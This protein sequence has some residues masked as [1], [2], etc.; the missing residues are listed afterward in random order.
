[1]ESRVGIQ[2]VEELDKLLKSREPP[3][4][5]SK[6]DAANRRMFIEMRDMSGAPEL[7]YCSL[8]AYRE[9]NNAQY[10]S[11]SPSLLFP[12][13][14]RWNLGAVGEE[15]RNEK[16]RRAD[17]AEDFRK[18]SANVCME[19]SLEESHFPAFYPSITTR[20]EGVSCG[21][22]ALDFSPPELC[23][24]LGVDT[25]YASNMQLLCRNPNPNPN[26]NSP[27]STYQKLRSQKI[28]HGGKLEHL[29]GTG[30]AL[31]PT[32]VHLSSSHESSSV[33]RKSTVEEVRR[34]IL[35]LREGI[36]EAQQEEWLLT[37]ASGLDINFLEL[38]SE[39]SESYSPK[40][41]PTFEADTG[42]GAVAA[43]VEG[44]V[45]AEIGEDRKQ[46]RLQESALIDIADTLSAYTTT[47]D[48]ATDTARVTQQA[49]TAGNEQQEAEV[50]PEEVVFS[51]EKDDTAVDIASAAEA[52]IETIQAEVQKMTQDTAKFLKEGVLPAKGATSSEASQWASI[53]TQE[54][55]SNFS[56][57]VPK[58]ALDVPF[59]LDDFQKRAVVHLER[60]ESVFVGAHTSAGKT[61]VAEYA[62]ALALEHRTRVVYTSPIKALSNQKFRDFQRKFG[63][64]QV[65]LIT[66]DVSLNP[67]GACLV[68]T[69]EILRSMLYRGA[70]IVRD[71]EWVVFDEVHY[72]ND[73]DRGVVWEEVIIMLPDEVGLIFLSATTPNTREFSSWIGRTKRKNVFVI[74]TDKRPVPL[75]HFLFSGKDFHMIKDSKG[76]FLTAGYTAAKKAKMGA[77]KPQNKANSKSKPTPGTTLKAR[78]KQTPG[79]SSG[80]QQRSRYM[81]D[82]A[83]AEYWATLVRRLDKDKLTPTVVFTFSKKKCDERAG[84][85]TTIDL[86]SPAEKSRIHVLFRR[87]LARLNPSDRELPQVQRI[88]TLCS[89][90]IAVHHGGLLPILKEIVEILFARGLIKVL[91]ATETFAIGVNMPARAVVFNGLRKHD[92]TA[93]RDLLPGEYT[94]MAGRAGRRGLDTV[95]TVII[96]M[97]LDPPPLETLTTML[98]GKATKLQSR[99]RL[100]YNLILNLLRVAELS[101]AEMMKRSFSEFAAQKMMGKDLATL[102]T[103]GEAKLTYLQQQLNADS[104]SSAGH[105]AIQ[106]FQRLADHLQT[107]LAQLL[108]EIKAGQFGPKPA[109]KLL[110][111]GRVVTVISS[112]NDIILEPCRL[113]ASGQGSRLLVE[114]VEGRQTDI[115]LEAI[116]VVTTHVASSRMELNNI[117]A[118][119]KLGAGGSSEDT[120]DDNSAVFSPL[121]ADTI[122]PLSD[123]KISQL[124]FVTR[125]REYTSQLLTLRESVCAGRGIN[126]T[127]YRQVEKVNG[128]A[129]TLQKAKLAM[130]DENLT[131]FPDFQSRL[132]LLK[133]RRYIDPLDSTVRLKGR[134]SSEINTCEELILTEVVFENVL[135]DLDA[136]ECAALLSALVFQAKTNDQP[137]LTDRLQEAQQRVLM[138][139]TTLDNLQ[140]KHRV[141]V[142]AD[143]V[144][145][146]LNFGLMEVVYEWAR[147]VPF[148]EICQLTTVEEGTIVRCIT[149]LDETCRE[150]RTIANVIGDA[151]LFKKMQD[152][153][154]A[155]KRD[156]IFATSLYIS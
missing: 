141:L 47:A 8:E 28:S 139:A 20:H 33:G 89:K 93:F 36:T 106:E 74:T 156:I 67:T 60:G 79:G 96:A 29:R 3:A 137:T 56:A 38:V 138:I 151:A 132:E 10:H 91:F 103:D 149:R 49:D 78:G 73:V 114:T 94:Q 5:T 119:E 9:R 100:T 121:L 95:G 127:R 143:W 46:R 71:I 51:E 7:I 22:N 84:S 42:E 27:R 129:K 4:S 21:F 45:D 68:M 145:K 146:S 75:Q 18:I 86:T 88:E 70:D 136:A 131:L 92:G 81:N 155:I 24:N 117:V 109:K 26:P 110:V 32:S 54:D 125:W 135:A 97:P 142:D 108:A 83:A 90:G 58:L 13:F 105:P 126:R 50:D 122:D 87:S 107:L 101:V 116:L 37:S 12:D 66:G 6:D 85:L 19:K 148:S 2:A 39:A 102:V 124:D 16:S 113:L 133:E 40:D 55:M 150:V 153:S 120:A 48:S 44:H 65:G 147:G 43:A 11:A 14:S 17:L 69:T 64:D 72:I 62:I 134:V 115:P 23:I 34:S 15:G 63:S 35:A 140:R 59:E 61:I 118:L 82:K 144:Q 111:E 53:A 130:S 52:S 123:L 76:H 152:A 112:A 99:F 80:G 25:E 98:V 77:N 30:R 41:N 57:M 104:S 1:M 154:S 128:L 31:T